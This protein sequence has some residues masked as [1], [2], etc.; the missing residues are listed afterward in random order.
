MESYQ[1]CKKSGNNTN[2][3]GRNGHVLLRH[4]DAIRPKIDIWFTRNTQRWFS[5]NRFWN[6]VVDLLNIVLKLNQCHIV[7]SDSTLKFN[8][9]KNYFVL[10]LNTLLVLYYNTSESIK[11]NILASRRQPRFKVKTLSFHRSERLILKQL[12]IWVGTLDIISVI[13]MLTKL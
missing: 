3:R 4:Y 12:W 9:K 2:S 11:K 5:V 1:F 8:V 10:R 6:N 7:N 13:W